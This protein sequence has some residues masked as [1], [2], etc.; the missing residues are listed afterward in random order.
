[1]KPKEFFQRWWAGILALSVE[2]QTKIKLI[3]QLGI[4]AS[5]AGG[6]IMLFLTK[7][8]YVGILAMFF[9]GGAI[10]EYISIRQQLDNLKKL[11]EMIE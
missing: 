3:L 7:Y 8:W 5:Y 1:M 2:Q 9:L 10:L 11:K 6:A 4:I